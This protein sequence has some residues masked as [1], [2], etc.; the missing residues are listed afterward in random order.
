MRFGGGEPFGEADDQAQLLVD[1]RPQ[2]RQFDRFAERVLEQRD[3]A[4][5][6]LRLDLGHQ[7]ERLCSLGAGRRP[8]DEV[9]RQL[10]CSL[11]VARGEMSPSCRERPSVRVRKALGGREAKRMLAELGRDDRRPLAGGSRC[12]LLERGREPGVRP[13]RR[14]R[15]M[16]STR[17]R[18]GDELRQ[19]AVG[20]LPFGCRKSLI[21]NRGEQW[22]REAN[23][24]TLELDHV[25]RERRVERA[26]L[27]A[28]VAELGHGQPCVRGGEHERFA[29]HA[30]EAGEPGGHELLQPLGD[31]QRLCRIP[32]RALCAHRPSELEGIERVAARRLVQPE[33]CRA[34]PPCGRAGRGAAGGSRRR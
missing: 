5:R 23:R 26:L 11:D 17:D 27:D 9:A 32:N 8:R 28:Q 6:L 20:A 10:P 3:H 16:P 2:S 7:Q 30:G 1:R 21:E 15:E 31:G 33:Q 18:V 12:R 34:V 4:S 29:R 24:A 14:E 22:M 25:L 19:P 13:V